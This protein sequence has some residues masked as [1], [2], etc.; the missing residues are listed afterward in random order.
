MTKRRVQ[1]VIGVLNLLC[2]KPIGR[3]NRRFDYLCAV[4]GM[5]VWTS[6]RCSLF[7]RNCKQRNQR[8][9]FSPSAIRWDRR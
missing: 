6:E 7:A 4:R 5:G 8:E 2:R 9:T 3:K 1:K